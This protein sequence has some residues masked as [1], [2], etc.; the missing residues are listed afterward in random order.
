VTGPGEK[1]LRVLVISDSYFDL[2]QNTI[3]P[4]IFAGY[5][6]WYYNKWVKTGP[7]ISRLNSIDK[8]DLLK[9]IR[10]F[11]VILLMVS[12]VNM[13]AAFFGFT[14]ETYAALHPGFPQNPV[15]R[16]EET[17]R[18]TRDWFTQ[19]AGKA[20]RVG[21]SLERMITIDARYQFF[22]DYPNLTNKTSADSIEYIACCMRNDPKTNSYIRGKARKNNYS[23]DQMLRMDASWIYA[24]S[25][26]KH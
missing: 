22:S 20:H 8:F 12:Q 26:K 10:Q 18:N 11:D 25:K 5:E 1:K 2:V 21:Y 9:K 7:G 4:E 14:E 16:Y 15:L 17:I 19:V 3:A 13:H 6:Y 24:E 23:F